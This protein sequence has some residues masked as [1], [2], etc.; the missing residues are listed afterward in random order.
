M[1]SIFPMNNGSSPVTN[2]LPVFA[3]TKVADTNGLRPPSRPM[4]IRDLMLHTSGLTYGDG[5]DAF[6][7]AYDR[8]KPLEST[9]RVEMTGKLSQVPLAFD[10]GTDWMYG[11]RPGMSGNTGGAA[12][13]PR[14]SGGVRPTT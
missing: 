3:D 4:T 14:T 6:K 9:N 2:Y 7:R 11:T 10:P 5:P 1:N 12:L 13:L 8:L